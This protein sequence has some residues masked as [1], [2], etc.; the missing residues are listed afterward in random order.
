MP[1]LICDTSPLQ[2]L[3]QLDLL[4]VLPELAEQVRV[5]PAVVEEL[6]EGREQGIDLPVPHTY[7]WIAIQSP[8]SAPALPLITD[9]GPGEREVLALTLESTD[10]VAVLDDKVARRSAQRLDLQFTGTLGLL[11][12]A[13]TAGLIDMIAPYLDRLEVL[14]FHLADS[15]RQLIL[16]RAEEAFD[17]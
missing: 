2:Y 8:D 4:S 7:S 12:D 5:P 13:K 15:T 9:L 3:Y 14:N 11:L 10:C 6:E 1:E 16:R 17:E